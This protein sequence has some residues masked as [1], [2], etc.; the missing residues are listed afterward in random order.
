MKL[1]RRLKR[2]LRS[3]VRK[4]APVPS[5]PV[6]QVPSKPIT[7]DDVKVPVERR[8]RFPKGYIEETQARYNSMIVGEGLLGRQ[9]KGHIEWYKKRL[10]NGRDRYE[11]ASKIV[12]ER[13][14][15]DIPWQI[16]GVIHGMEAGFDFNKQILNG[17]PINRKTT[18]VPKN[19][20]P[21]S[22]W[23]ESCVDAFTWDDGYK[24]I[25]TEWTP[26]NTALFNERWNGMSYWNR[27]KPTP[28]LWGYTNIQVA[29][30][31]VSDGKYDRRA[32]TLQV[33]V[34]AQLEEV[35]FWE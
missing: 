25:P 17:Q 2:W 34:M 10:L 20:G 9:T 33:G 22:S 26:E 11:K 14:G 30:K 29:G 24:I 15:Y 31:Y 18:W 32:V 27:G 16:I 8:Q 23:E 7:V 4:P 6:V 19:R 21:W 1:F 13:T 12:L 35:G 28:Y 5:K 3:L